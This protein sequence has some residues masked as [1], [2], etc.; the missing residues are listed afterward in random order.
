M[1]SAKVFAP[2]ACLLALALPVSAQTIPTVAD[3]TQL[4]P[5]N[6]D[7]SLLSMRGGR[8]LLAEASAAIQAQNYTLAVTKLQQARQVFNQ[9]SNLYQQLSASFSGID[10]RTAD[11][12]R[13]GAVDAAE[14]RD[15]ATYQ[16]ALVHRAQNQPELSVPLLVQVIRS[17][18][19]T[20]DLGKKAYTQLLE[21]GFVNDAASTTSTR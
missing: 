2:L 5:L 4:R 7:N 17:Q 14:Q 20:T 10:N 8:R 3:P 18:N 21:L 16:L 12:L 6:Q 19:P 11:I 13:S 9:I 15:E 1:I